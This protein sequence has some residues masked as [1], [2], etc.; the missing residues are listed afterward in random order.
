MD[1]QSLAYKEYIRF[2]EAAL[3]SVNSTAH[4]APISKVSISKEWP[5]VGYRNHLQNKLLTD[6]F[7]KGMSPEIHRKFSGNMY[8]S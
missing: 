7:Y 5:I 2:T 3:K 6:N 1:L 4:G 8:Y